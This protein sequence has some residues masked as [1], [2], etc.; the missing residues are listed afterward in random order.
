MSRPQG[1]LLAGLCAAGLL[2]GACW[3]W[4]DVTAKCKDAGGCADDPDGALPG[5]A[6]DGGADGGDAGP[7]CDYRFCLLSSTGLDASV[8]GLWVGGPN[9]VWTAGG[10]PNQVLH[11]DGTRWSDLTPAADDQLLTVWGTGPSNMFLGGRSGNVFHSNGLGQWTPLTATAALRTNVT[12]ISGLPDGGSV[13]A[14]GYDL[15]RIYRWN[16]VDLTRVSE[17]DAGLDTSLWDVWAAAE[18]DVWAAG[19]RGVLMHSDGT[20]WASVDAGISDGGDPPNFYAVWATGADDVWVAG[21]DG[22]LNAGIL[23]HRNSQGWSLSKPTPQPLYSFWGTDRFNLWLGG[24]G[25][26][27]LHYDGN[28]WSPVVPGV[29]GI[30]FY[31]LSGSS[32]EGVWAA[33]PVFDSTDSHAYVRHYLR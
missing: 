29:P 32:P 15:Q 11:F 33:G 5:P 22:N 2:L 30:H 24:G 13:Y 23:L 28:G 18:N 1:W 7:P 8:N 14:T 19:S 4:S 16:G 27:L 17:S 3:N 10:D 20:G 12:R 9:D 25:G 21:Y 26:T 31:Q 6:D